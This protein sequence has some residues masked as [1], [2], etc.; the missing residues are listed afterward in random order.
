MTNLFRAKWIEQ[1]H[2]E[3]IRNLQEERFNLTPESVQRI[4]IRTYTK[5]LSGLPLR[6]SIVA[7]TVRFSSQELTVPRSALFT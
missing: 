3:W 4:S 2:D 1:I 6:R 5:G 7:V